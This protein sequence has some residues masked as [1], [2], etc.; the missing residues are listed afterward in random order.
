[1]HNIPNFYMCNFTHTGRVSR[2]ED[3]LFVYRGSDTYSSVN[4]DT[5][6]T[7]RFG[8]NNDSIP[9]D[10]KMACGGNTQCL[11]DYQQTGDV[12][13]AESTASEE[14]ELNKTRD[15][16]GQCTVPNVP[17]CTYILFT[18]ICVLYVRTYI[19]T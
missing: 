6:F 10:V 19:R 18:H 13:L 12:G 3:S 4:D 14:M 9:D 15:I 16:L 5:G 11:F 8:V 1:M 7:P 17:L 2:E